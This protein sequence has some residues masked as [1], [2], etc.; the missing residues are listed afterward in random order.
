MRIARIHKKMSIVWRKFERNAW[1]TDQCDRPGGGGGRMVPEGSAAWANPRLD[2]SEHRNLLSIEHGQVIVLQQKLKVFCQVQV[3]VVISYFFGSWPPEQNPGS[4][5]R[6]VNKR[7]S[8]PDGGVNCCS[9]L[10]DKA[11]SNAEWSFIPWQWP[12][13]RKKHTFLSRSARALSKEKTVREQNFSFCAKTPCGLQPPV[14]LPP[15]WSEKVIG[16]DFLSDK[17]IFRMNWE[18]ITCHLPC[19]TCFSCLS[20]GWISPTFVL[21]KRIKITDTC[22][23]PWCTLGRWTTWRAWVWARVW[24]PC[25]ASWRRWGWRRSWWT[26]AGYW[27]SPACRVH[28][29]APPRCTGTGYT[30]MGSSTGR[31]PLKMKEKRRET[32]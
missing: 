22:C 6:D 4:P 24:T 15:G 2:G 13:Q 11:I 30:R 31:T 26:R 14:D 29:A 10:C 12:R 28:P 18:I 1:R 8:I 27:W 5:M 32:N 7:V 23:V 20:Q 25:W 3:A 17:L 9:P 19:N 16:S 21:G